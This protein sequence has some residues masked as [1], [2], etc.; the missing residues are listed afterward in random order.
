VLAPED[1][2]PEAPPTAVI[3]YAYWTRRFNNNPSAVGQVLSVNGILLT[4]AGVAPPE[5]FGESV[6][7]PLADFW[8]PLSLQP[9]LMPDRGSLLKNAEVNWLNLVARL[10]P[11]VGLQQAQA[12]VDVAFRQFLT[13]RAG[14]RPSAYEGRRIQGSYIKLNPGISGVSALRFLYSRPLRILMA[15][16]ALVLLIACANVANILLSRGAAG[17]RKSPCGWPWER[18]ETAWCGSCLPRAS[19]WDCWEARWGYSFPRGA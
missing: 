9:R 3:S 7:S 2:R 4:V 15:V 19:C 8:F 5:F 12:S 14:P 1:D 10:K 18:A 17:G 11:G 13:E 16:V 6:E